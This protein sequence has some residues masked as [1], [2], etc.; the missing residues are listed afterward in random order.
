MAFDHIAFFTPVQLL[1]LDIE[2][3]CFGDA[4]L[5]SPDFVAARLAEYVEWIHD[6]TRDLACG[7]L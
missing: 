6:A 5:A 7:T 2:D 3:G 1:W 4:Q